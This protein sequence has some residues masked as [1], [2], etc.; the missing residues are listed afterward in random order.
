M[1]WLDKVRAYF[2]FPPRRGRPPRA[3]PQRRN[4]SMSAPSMRLMNDVSAIVTLAQLGRPAICSRCAE[5]ISATVT[6]V[7]SGPEA[8]RHGTCPRDLP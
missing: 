6:A 1:K 4:L 7:W 2:G 8:P 3:L 5:E